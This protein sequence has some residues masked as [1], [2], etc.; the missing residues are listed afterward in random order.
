[1]NKEVVLLEVAQAEIN[2]WLDFKQVAQRKRDDNEDSIAN[3]VDAVRYGHM[4]ID[5]KTKV[6]TQTLKFPIEG[7]AGQKTEKI[8]FKPRVKMS[9]IGTQLAGT[10]MTD[11]VGLTLSYMAAVTGQPKGVLK[12]MMSDD[13]SVASSVVVFF[14]S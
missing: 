8:E 6:I 14:V 13:Y 4:T 3:L 2:A 12:E 9:T 11:I 10:K 5:P 7:E 1:M